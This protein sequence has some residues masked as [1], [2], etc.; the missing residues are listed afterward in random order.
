MNV[1]QTLREP[2]VHFPAIGVGLPLLYG[3]VAPAQAS[4][5]R[6]VVPEARVADQARQYQATWN[7]APTPQEPQTPIHADVRLAGERTP[8]TASVDAATLGD[9]AILPPLADVRAEVIREWENDRRTKA[10]EAS[11]ARLL[12][13]RDVVIEGKP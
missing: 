11:E 6:I 8:A 1:R 9:A 12:K 3:E 13:Q 4:G 10:S 5:Q 2:L 7:L